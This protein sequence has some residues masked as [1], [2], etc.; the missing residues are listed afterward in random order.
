MRRPPRSM[1]DT[2]IRGRLFHAGVSAVDAD[3]SCVHLLSRGAPTEQ[4]LCEGGVRCLLFMLGDAS[5]CLHLAN[6]QR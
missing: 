4:D 1:Q 2:G 5:A 3:S 6:V